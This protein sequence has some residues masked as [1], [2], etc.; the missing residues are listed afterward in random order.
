MKSHSGI[1][2]DN[3]PK[4]FGIK[5]VGTPLKLSSKSEKVIKELKKRFKI[6]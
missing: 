6:K 5:P 4:L 2:M 3:P 1:V